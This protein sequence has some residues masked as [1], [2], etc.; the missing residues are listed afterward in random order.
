MWSATKCPLMQ[1]F[2]RS[3]V[4]RSRPVLI[5]FI[6]LWLG[7]ISA[8]AVLFYATGDPN[9]N[10]NAPGG[11]LTNS[12]W[13][14]EGTWVGFLGTPIAP[15][16]FIAAGHVGG[17]VGAPFVFRGV[18][19]T[20][21]AVYDDPSSDL[22]I[23]RVCGT[24]PDYAQIYTNTDEVNKSFVVFGRGTQRGATVTTTNGLF[25]VKT[26]GWQWGAGDGVERWGTNT[27]AATPDDGNTAGG[28]LQA[29]FDQNGGG[30]ECHLSN[31][32]SSGAVFIRDGSV[33]KLAGINYGLN[34]PYNTTNTGSGFPA[35]I[36]DE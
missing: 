36:F 16:Y 7:G 30:N 14:F 1:P 27:V 29:T 18:T 23:W 19:Y 28:F 3:C 17:G 10:T 6:S 20:T 34:G 11:S 12:G 13:Q 4:S 8:N 21:T 2:A 5:V 24:F 32:D 31:G 35:A 33:W 26:N 22:R 15:K 25:V 9:Y